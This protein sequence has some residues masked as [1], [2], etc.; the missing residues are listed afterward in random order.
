M[1]PAKARR[2]NGWQNIRRR[3]RRCRR[4]SGC[5]TGDQHWGPINR[6]EVTIV[7]AVNTL[8]MQVQELLGAPPVPIEPKPEPEPEAEVTITV[9]SKGAVKINVVEEPDA[10]L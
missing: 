8:L 7:P 3:S 6:R 9:R 2:S 10:I 4:R 5:D 1:A